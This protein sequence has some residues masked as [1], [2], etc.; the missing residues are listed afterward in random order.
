M[1][2]KLSQKS[3]N[4]FEKDFLKFMI[5]VA[6]G[7][8]MENVRKH[9]NIKLVTTERRRNYLVSEQNYHSTKFFAE[10]VLAIEMRKTQILRNK[11]V[12][13]DLSILDLK[14]LSKTVMYEFWSDY[15]KP[16]YGKNAKL[17]Y[18]DTDSFIVD[19]KTDDIYKGIADVETRFYT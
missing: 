19:V 8:T 7:K 4:N 16:K 1:N 11:P 5:N 14:D 2:T 13:I 12:Y 17:C 15:I 10:N 18:M 6:F 3:K 9:K